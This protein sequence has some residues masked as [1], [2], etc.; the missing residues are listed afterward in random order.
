MAFHDVTLCLLICKG[1][2][3]YHICPQVNAKDSH[4][5]RRRG[6]LSITNASDLW[7][8]GC[9]DICY[10]FLQDVKNEVSILHLSHNGEKL[11]TSRLKSAACLETSEPDMPIATPVSA[12]LEGFI[13]LVPSPVNA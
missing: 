1:Y 11:S 4:H 8:I 2:G 13:S 9:E 7:H 3:C 5:P 6:M 10:G 12:F